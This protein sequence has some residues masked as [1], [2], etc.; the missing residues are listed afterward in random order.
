MGTSTLLFVQPLPGCDT[1]WYICLRGP[2]FST[3]SYRQRMYGLDWVSQPSLPY[4]PAGPHL[5]IARPCDH[6]HHFHAPRRPGGH[7][8]LFS[9]IPL[10][11]PR[12]RVELSPEHSNGLAGQVARGMGCV[13]GLGTG[14]GERS[15]LSLSVCSVCSVV[16]V[17]FDHGAQGTRRRMVVLQ[18]RCG[19]G[20]AG[21]LRG[22]RFPYPFASTI[23][24]AADRGGRERQPE[25][26]GSRDGRRER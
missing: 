9:A 14:R 5:W 23:L 3:G 4:M 1:P 2:V 25:S 21:C 16:L 18:R 8:R 15:L 22:Y 7:R 11:P 10:C 26:S 19:P 13:R 12:L 6:V 17:P 24:Q 20:R